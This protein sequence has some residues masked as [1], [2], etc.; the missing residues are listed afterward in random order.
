MKL[1]QG[2]NSENYFKEVINYPSVD[3]ELELIFGYEPYHNPITKK[4]YLDLIQKCKE[5]YKLLS[6]ESSLDI[7][8]KF[9]NNVSNIRCTIN[10]MDNIKKYCREDKLD[11]LEDIQYVIKSFY[12]NP[13][14]KSKKYP[15]LKDKDYNIRLNIKK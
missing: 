5:N 12:Q 4:V 8:K 3:I 10:G 11:N 1:L 14:D 9:K 6:E 13:F 2:K 7:R 15:S